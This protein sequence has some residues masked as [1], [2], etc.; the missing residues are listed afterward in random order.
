M[1]IAKGAISQDAN[2]RAVHNDE[3]TTELLRLI[4][5]G[6][7]SDSVAIQRAIDQGADVNA[8][9]GTV[10][11]IAL[12]H[13][14]C[15]G[16]YDHFTPLLAQLLR[17]GF[18]IHA[19]NDA[20]LRLAHYRGYVDKVK[21]LLAHGSNPNAALEEL[22]QFAKPGKT[23]GAGYGLAAPFENFEETHP[24][25]TAS[26]RHLAL[27]G[28]IPKKAA[29]AKA[30]DDT[31][32]P[33]YEDYVLNQVA[34]GSTD[35]VHAMAA[36]SYKTREVFVCHRDEPVIFIA[37]QTRLEGTYSLETS[38][39]MGDVIDNRSEHGYREDYNECEA[40]SWRD[41][42]P[43]VGCISVGEM[44][45]AE[46][47]DA[48]EPK[49]QSNFGAP[50]C[51]VFGEYDCDG[52]HENTVCTDFTF[53]LGPPWSFEALLQGEIARGKKALLGRALKHTL[54]AMQSAGPLLSQGELNDIVAKALG[55]HHN[56]TRHK[57]LAQSLA[58][59]SEGIAQAAAPLIKPKRAD[60]AK[61][62]PRSAG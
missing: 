44:F 15:D 57:S 13:V 3:A 12:D 43:S 33:T 26:A 2:Q 8:A 55:T 60:T 35:P 61:R 59:L 24:L 37:P 58:Q 38:T 47:G 22:A 9:N 6:G 1:N 27:M 17:A 21:V 41:S 11:L 7:G 56:S 31:T 19:N 34:G 32:L 20:A 62:S 5:V 49:E 30:Q 54:D 52:Q 39:N 53:H 48:P 45:G 14:R 16:R 10:I 51:V 18:D 25:L 28:G 4:Q 50:R 29:N 42:G 36:L 23:S 40:Y 46:S